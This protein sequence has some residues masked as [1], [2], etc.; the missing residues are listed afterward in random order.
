MQ[1]RF[2]ARYNRIFYLNAPNAQIIYTSSF[3]QGKFVG[4]FCSSNLGDVSPNIMGPKCSLSGNECD[5][6]TSKCPADEGE[7]FA[8]GPGKDMF[9]STK[10]IGE[11]LAEGAL[12]S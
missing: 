3:L 10:M 12:V 6:L 9:E 4:A 11:R 1:I 2:L 7:C 5:I 8:S